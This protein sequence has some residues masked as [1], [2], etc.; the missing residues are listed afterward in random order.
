MC[1]YK[2]QHKHWQVPSAGV[3]SIGGW[4]SAVKRRDHELHSEKDKE[5]LW[6]S[7]KTDKGHL[8]YCKI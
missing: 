2:P 8:A 5:N 6:E 7:L 1:W 3:S 4:E